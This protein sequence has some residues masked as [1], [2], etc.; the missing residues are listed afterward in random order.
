MT[1]FD[2]IL[3]LILFGFALYGLWFGLIHALG[4]F[5]GVFV[6]S[7]FTSHFYMGVADFL[8]VDS[9]I[10]R[11]FV[12]FIMFMIIMRLVGLLF[13]FVEK[14][15]NVVSIIPFLKTIN[16]LAGAIL[17]AAVGVLVIGLLLYVAGKYDLGVVTEAMANS[18]FAPYFLAATYILL[19]LL[20]EALKK[21]QS[22]I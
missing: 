19:P 2:L 8:T 22:F 15:F 13:Y 3:V 7:Y 12:F 11:I 21:L 4:S 10:G 9:A 5:I 20:P 14:I 18:N 17:G 1:L 16:R 6:A